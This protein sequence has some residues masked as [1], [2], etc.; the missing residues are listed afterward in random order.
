MTVRVKKYCRT[1]CYILFLGSVLFGVFYPCAIWI[2]AHLFF[3]YQ[4]EGSPIISKGALV[5]FSSIGQNFS[6]PKYFSARPEVGVQEVSGG[7]NLSWSSPKLQEKV[8]DRRAL[9][10]KEVLP[11]RAL[12]ADLLTQSASGL[13]PHISL[14]AALFQVERVARARN[15][16]ATELETLVL[17]NCDFRW[18]GLFPDRVNV[19]L[20]NREL[21]RRTA[22]Q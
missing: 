10:E 15:M 20:L 17:E 8:A 14:K 11:I 7:S 16:A 4:A 9:L 19:L 13:D 21:D 18:C 3:P 2:V 22:N 12:P 1:S 5:G 6:S